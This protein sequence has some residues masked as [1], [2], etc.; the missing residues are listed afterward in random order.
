[1]GNVWQAY[2]V[3]SEAA[4][5]AQKVSVEESLYKQITQEFPPAPTN[6]E[7]LK[8]AVEVAK[9]IRESAREPLP[10]MSVVSQ[11][12][13]AT[14]QVALRE[15]TWRYGYSTE[16]AAEAS[17]TPAAVPQVA[18]GAPPPV[19]RQTAYISGEIRNFRGDYRG[20][21]ETINGLAERLR[22]HASVAEVRTIKMPLD[23]SP[24]AVLSGNT[25]ESRGDAATAEFEL[26]IV[27]KP[28]V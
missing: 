5:I 21:I 14:P 18:R 2:G 16:K 26:A 4:E 23:V 24:K 1:M 27:L 22:A 7:N 12:L 19:R 25:L 11:A 8:R 3:N 28:K 15:F 17:G 13:D 10:L 9:A 20:A 6:G